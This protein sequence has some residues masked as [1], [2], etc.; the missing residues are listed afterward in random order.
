MI[1]FLCRNARMHSRTSGCVVTLPPTFAVAM[2]GFTIMSALLLKLKYVTL[3]HQ[4]WE[5]RW[6]VPQP[7]HDLTPLDV[8]SPP[9]R[10]VSSHRPHRLSTAGRPATNTYHLSQPCGL[11]RNSSASILRFFF[12]LSDLLITKSVKMIMIISSRWQLLAT[13]PSPTKQLLLPL[14]WI[15]PDR[16]SSSETSPHR[17]FSQQAAR[18]TGMGND[19]KRSQHYFCIAI[20]P[21][22]P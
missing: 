6:E 17:A 7:P 11:R 3:W 18:A 10:R 22:S 19:E 12:N 1:P 14:L 15:Q 4:R 21:S 16:P 20:L 9:N 2:F 5:R 13:L 8:P